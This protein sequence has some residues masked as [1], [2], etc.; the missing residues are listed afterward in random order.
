MNSD[1]LLALA[2]GASQLLPPVQT[3]EDAKR[4]AKCLQA[5]S[6][7]AKRRG[8]A[9]RQPS[10]CQRR[11]SRC[12]R[13]GAGACGPALGS[14]PLRPSRCSC[15]GARASPPMAPR[16]AAW[17][18][19]APLRDDDSI[20][21]RLPPTQ[22]DEREKLRDAGRRKLEEFR[23][24]KLQGS[25]IEPAPATPP[26]GIVE[27]KLELLKLLPIELAASPVNDPPYTPRGI[28]ISLASKG[29]ERDP[30]VDMLASQVG[31]AGPGRPA[32][33]WRARD[34]SLPWCGAARTAPGLLHRRALAPPPPPPRAPQ[35][36]ALM[37]DKQRLQQEASRLQMENEQLQELV[38]YLTV[39]LEGSLPDT[40]DQVETE[41]YES[42]QPQGE[43]GGEEEEEGMLVFTPEELQHALRHKQRQ[44]EEEKQQQQQQQRAAGVLPAVGSPSIA[45]A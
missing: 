42:L 35:V 23:R 43:L 14:A 22:A 33:C 26:V 38:G 2:S 30:L 21:T 27:H 39:Q 4:V 13:L 34:G 37:Q 9:G 11:A 8:N 20:L 44:Q 32:R 18:R 28:S 24:K 45:V 16:D 7:A 29:H 40:E 19:G 36:N 3:A 25:R 6:T 1:E 41:N 5:R 10:G 15:A 12:Q 31:W 17:C